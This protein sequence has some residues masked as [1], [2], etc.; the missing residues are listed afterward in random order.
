MKATHRF[1]LPTLAS[2]LVLLAPTSAAGSAA[3]A[4]SFNVVWDSPSTN[5]HGS[6]PLGNGDLSLNA[7]IE[8][9][10]DLCFYIGKS[11]AWD[12]YSRLL[13]IGRVRVSL[14]PA[15]PIRPFHQEL[16]LETGTL[17]VR[18][19]D[20][21]ALRLWADAHHPA[22]HVDVTSPRPVTATARAELWRTNRL[23]LP[24]IECSDVLTDRSK[25]GN[26]HAPT[27][28]EPDTVVTG[29]GDRVAWYHRN[30]KS[31]GPALHAE[32]QGVTGYSRPDPLL[33]RTFGA[34]LTAPRGRKLDDLTLQS[35]AA[36]SHHFALHALTRHPSTAEA[37]LRDLET[38]AAATDQIPLERRRQAHEEWWR[39]FWERS[40]IRAT[41]NPDIA[42]TPAA[43]PIIPTNRH[44]LRVG[45]DQAGGNRFAGE[46]RNT[47][48]PETLAVPFTLEAEV[49]PGPG[50]SGRLFDQIT[51]GG[52]D[53]FLL[54][55]HPGN[56]LRL[57]LGSDQYTAR[58][59]LP[60]GQWLRVVA[61]VDASGARVSV[62][63]REVIN[64]AKPATPGDDAAYVSQMYALQRFIT[65]C[66]GRGAYPIK[67]NGSLFTVPAE[68]RP[69][70]A[71]YRQWGPGYWWQN[72]RLPYLSVCASG[73]FELLEP[74]FRMYVD[75]LL[76]FNRYRTREYFG[77]DGAY[78]AE[79][80]HFW[81][82]VFN[83]TYGWTP[84][85][86]RQDPLQ[87]S[88]YHK[89][90]WVSGPE[91]VWMMLEAYDHTGDARLLE[92]RIL[93]TADAVMR[94]FDGYYRTNAAGRLVMHPSQA[95]ETWWDCTNPM[96]E[97]AGLH[98]ITARLL[99]LP[100][101][102]TPPSSR[103]W[104]RTFA[105]KLPPLPTRDTPDGPAL[106]PAEVFKA[107]SNVEN[108]ELYA[109]FPFRLCSF[110]KENRDLG[111]RALWHRWDRGSFG[112]RQDDLFMAYL[113]LAAEA[114]QNVVERARNHDRNSRFPAFWGPNYDW[115]PDQDHGGVL[116]KAVQSMLLQTDGRRLFLLPAWPRE[117]DVSFKLHA[118]QQTTVE[119]TVRGGAITALKVTP[120]SRRAD[121]VLPR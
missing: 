11:D 24:S 92:R 42:A 53:G 100:E 46:I 49:R 118:P 18:F 98:A 81:G 105:A 101:S 5:H 89:W 61:V 23:E 109:V 62:D 28:V 25:P 82:D 7:W 57:I 112:W 117:W 31:V 78:Y 116:M 106:A 20:G 94:F 71:D 107:K 91:L 97:L 8:P 2:A 90:E 34:L 120:E 66:A 29:L 10:G 70:D 17:D 6:M 4:P 68:G 15:P 47:R 77:I 44:P 95:L 59:V 102:I 37:W 33:H 121:V 39:A 63:G 21:T 103:A 43:A 80:I 55:A 111:L 76:P 65:A 32:T 48:V 40:W 74:L 41:R 54:D 27:V 87:E 36:T 38:Q 67:F 93:P 104:W 13:K 96:P 12:D 115:V 16:T 113:G 75:D 52:S 88:G 110:E 60:A 99:A 64:T 35:P 58:D 9:S 114:R 83:E 26:M 73:D 45:V 30:I 1:L 50:E 69:G 56:S 14:D 85:S 86:Q 19:G 108:P 72:T 3:P 79:C 84:R 119:G 51:P 22:I